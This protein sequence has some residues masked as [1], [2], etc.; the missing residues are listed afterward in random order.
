MNKK[1][2][3]SYVTDRLRAMC[4]RREY[5]SSDIRKKA[6]ALLEGNKD[7]ADI[8]LGKLIQEKYVDDRRYSCAY[9]R[10]KASISGWGRVKIRYMLSA[11]GISRDIIEE[12]LSE[13][14]CDTSDK[15]FEKLLLNKY[16]SLKRGDNVRLKM[17]RF[18]M[19]R[20]H[21]YEQSTEL[22]DRIISSEPCFFTS[23]D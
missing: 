1:I 8:V 9:A 10:D 20:G 3:A 16:Q 19:G 7:E 13:I 21:D 12:A 17:L 15:R 6:L 14:D 11:K 22:I 23:N 4:S 5:C 2:E 18:A